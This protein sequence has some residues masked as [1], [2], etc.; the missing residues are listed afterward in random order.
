MIPLFSIKTSEPL[1]G[2]AN[3]HFNLKFLIITSKDIQL[4]G[5]VFD[6]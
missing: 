5:I 2:V 6:S 1:G 4:V 3:V